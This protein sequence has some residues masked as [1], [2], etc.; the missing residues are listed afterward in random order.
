MKTIYKIYLIFLFLVPTSTFAGSSVFALVPK[1]LGEHYY[2]YSIAAYGR[3]GFS[4]AFV[5]SLTLNQVN[6][7]LWAYIPRTTFSLGVSYQGLESESGDNQISSIDGQFLGGYLAVPLVAR[8]LAVG[9]GILPTSINNQGFVLTDVGEGA[10]ATQTLRTKGTLSEV[11]FVASWAPSTNLAL[12]LVVYYVLGK[13]N[14]ETLIEYE[15]R[16]YQAV[17]VR[18]E[19]QFYG[20]GPS[21]AFSGFYRMTP[22]LAVGGRVKLATTLRQF[23]QQATI[24]ANQTIEK[25]QDITF[26]MNFTIG[27]AWTPLERLLIGGDLD[28]VDW[29]TGYLF[30]GRPVSG[31]NSSYRIGAGIDLLPSQRRLAAYGAKMNYRAGIFYGQMNFMSNGQPVKEFG[32]SLGLGMP[33]TRGRSRLDIAFQVGKRGDIDINGLSEIFFRLNFSLSANELWFVRDER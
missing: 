18:N 2:P 16:S 13:I 11:Q 20:K 31:M 29:D 26:P 12:G 28:Y 15:D 33:I 32:A 14:D 27:A 5:D 23:S 30:D 7:S 19:Y 6:T 8:K 24:T 25:F 17:S 21:L 1:S 9:F 4:M 3:G 10:P 22:R